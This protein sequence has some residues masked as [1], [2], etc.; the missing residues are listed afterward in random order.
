MTP[1]T[2]AAQ[3]V[4]VYF[5]SKGTVVVPWTY[6]THQFDDGR[7]GGLAHAYALTA[8]KAQGSTMDTARALV[9]DDT[10]RAGLYVMLSRARTDLAAY[11]IRR[12]DLTA[13]DDDE[14]WLPATA[15]PL[16]PI[17]RLAAHLQHSEPE[18]TAAAHD[19][20]ATA[21]HQLRAT[22]TLA[23]LTALRLSQRIPQP[24]LGARRPT[25]IAPT[26]TRP[27]RPGAA[28]TPGPSRQTAPN[29]PFEPSRTAPNAP[30]EPSRAT[31]VEPQPRAT[32]S[33]P[34]HCAP[35]KPADAQ[36]GVAGPEA[37]SAAT[38][39]HAY[40]NGQAL[41]RP[42]WQVVL[43]RAE[44]AAE[45]AIRTA[46]LADPP[47]GLVDRIGPRPTAG[48]QR[49]IWDA[50]A[51]GLAVYHARHKPAAPS[52]T[53]GPPPGAT[54][55]DRAHDPWLQ[56]HDQAVHLADAWAATFPDPVRAGFTGPGQTVPRQRAIAGL[57]ALLDA[58]HPPADLAAT[59]RQGPI[60]DIQ[61]AAAILDHRVTDL[62]HHAGIDPTL[63]DLP[64]PTTAQHEW[65]TTF[66]L[67]TRAETTHLATHPTHDLATE[68]RSLTTALTRTADH[69]APGLA[70]AADSGTARRLAQG[71]RAE[72]ENRLRRVEAALDR[73]VTDALLH[74]QS[75]PAD[76]LTALLGPRPHDAGADAMSWEQAAGRIEHYRHHALGLPYGTPAQPDT[77][78]PTRHALGNRPTNPAD[79]AHYDQAQDI[80]DLHGGQLAM[81]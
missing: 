52:W 68:R 70:M 31:P 58:G 44:L 73:Q 54:P 66:D 79:A 38:A 60:H 51:G 24:R 34:A 42:P 81:E 16:D 53:A 72:L 4:T 50:A 21:A 11:L 7:D 78:D 75:E 18:H 74:A 69:A 46:A 29:A 14:N 15:G 80:A 30:A 41:S 33:R 2:P 25:A 10:S 6:L 49:A 3:T 27:A 1:D 45:A 55:H 22:H 17:S 5:P 59:L 39:D 77:A 56:L 8:A 47:D 19:P 26:T 13:R 48:P 63:Y 9:T 76:Y 35:N 57:H 67:L 65:N 62:C 20:I 28:R 61:T 71:E 23:Q 43:R 64:A 37:R 32:P 12:D 40:G 36:T